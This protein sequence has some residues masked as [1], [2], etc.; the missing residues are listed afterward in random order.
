ME[1]IN[2]FFAYYTS[3]VGSGAP[4]YQSRFH[5]QAGRGWFGNLFRSAWSYLRPLVT[6]AAKHAGAE[7]LNVG[8]NMMK[9]VIANPDASLKDVIGRQGKE[10]LTSIAKAALAGARAGQSGKGRGRRQSLARRRQGR[11]V[12]TNA[13]KRKR[14]ARPLPSASTIKDIFSPP[15]P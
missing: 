12:R 2:P 15:S 14:R 1:P 7:A 13:V 5:I 6:G 10:G 9:E 3:Q 11:S 4:Y 8:S